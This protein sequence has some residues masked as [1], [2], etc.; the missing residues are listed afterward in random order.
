MPTV[1]IDTS[2]TIKINNIATYVLLCMGGSNEMQ[3]YKSDVS[4]KIGINLVVS[5]KNIPSS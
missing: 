5:W 1:N 2:N 3:G 4:L